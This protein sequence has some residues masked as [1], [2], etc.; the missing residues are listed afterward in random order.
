MVSIRNLFDYGRFEGYSTTSV[1]KVR[2]VEKGLLGLSSSQPFGIRTQ[3]DQ[4]QRDRFVTAAEAVEVVGGV[5]AGVPFEPVRPS[6]GIT[7]PQL[8]PKPN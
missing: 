6:S 4:S 1:A 2:K 3:Q 8:R 7:Q 5:A